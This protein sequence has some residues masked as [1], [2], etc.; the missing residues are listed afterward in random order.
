MSL[1]L[2]KKE[3]EAQRNHHIT[4]RQILAQKVVEKEPRNISPNEDVT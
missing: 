1:P 2:L 4:V 3:T